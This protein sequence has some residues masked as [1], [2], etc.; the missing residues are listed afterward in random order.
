M[1]MPDA[2]R[3]ASVAATVFSCRSFDVNPIL[4]FVQIVNNVPNSLGRGNEQEADSLAK[5]LFE[6]MSKRSR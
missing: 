6:K 3:A 5:Y 2:L 4:A 1:D